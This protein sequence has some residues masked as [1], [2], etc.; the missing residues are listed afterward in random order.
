MKAEDLIKVS[1]Q[2]PGMLPQIRGEVGFIVAIKDGMAEIQTLHPDG[3][4]SGRGYVPLGCLILES[5]EQWKTAK[6][7]YDATMLRY[8]QEGEVRTRRWQDNIQR[9]ALKYGLTPEVVKA[10]YA[11]VQSAEVG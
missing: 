11:D 1:V 8:R 9:V 4:M 10:V 3:S 5:G 2:P 7:K 6:A